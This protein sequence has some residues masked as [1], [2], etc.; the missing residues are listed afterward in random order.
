MAKKQPIVI[1]G[2]AFTTKKDLQERVRSIL[3]SYKDG[4]AVNM[5][6][7]PFLLAL[8]DQHPD[9]EQKIG[10]GVNHIEVRRNPVYTQTQGFWIVRTDGTETDISYLECLTP[11][12]H[13]KRFERACRV[14]V[15]PSTMAFKQVFFDNAIG[16]Q[17]CPLTG[18][19]LT[20]IGSH[21]DHVA[22]QTFKSLLADFV[23]DMSLDIE[24]IQVD[25]RGI[26]GVVQDT[27]AD[28]SLRRQWIQYH[29][30]HAVL[31]VISRTGNL[32]HAKRKP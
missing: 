14:A 30:E 26:D 15:E 17:P 28:E 29:N 31:R 7:T 9:A 21:V 8:F 1:N 3:W 19:V 12:P 6:D 10:V 11:T 4:D 32:S 20:F 27:I 23:R 25:G 16:I 22:P 13:S 24:K 18:D 2:E 5:F